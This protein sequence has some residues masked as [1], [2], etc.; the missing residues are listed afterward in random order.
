[1]TQEPGRRPCDAPDTSTAADFNLQALSLELGARWVVKRPLPVQVAFA[2]ADGVL[3]T[4]EGEVGYRA[5]DALLTGDHGDNWPVSRA[6]FDE[7]YRPVSSSASQPGAYVKR[8]IPV[9]ARQIPHAFSVP[10][11][12]GSDL[13]HGAPGDWLLDYGNGRMGVVKDEIFQA[14]YCPADPP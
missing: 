5:G 3:Q 6:R 4:L 8:N 13:L 11:G 1:M 2:K 14:T 9:L 7:D 10:R 12:E